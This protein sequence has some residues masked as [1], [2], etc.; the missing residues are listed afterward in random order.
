MRTRTGSRAAGRFGRLV[1]LTASLTACTKW[2][3]QA[4]S[5]QQLLAE[6]QPA[7][8]R[9]TRADQT[10]IVLHHPELVGDTLYGIARDG[11]GPTEPRQGV[12]HSDVAQVAIRKKDPL[13]TGL[14]VFGSAAVAAGVGVLIWASSMPAD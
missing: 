12:P 14:L 1:L 2:Q 10:A 5:P 3:V 7:Q 6:G 11:A 13:A 9:I 4:V 8:V